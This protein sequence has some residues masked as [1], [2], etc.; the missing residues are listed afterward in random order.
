MHGHLA[1]SRRPDIIE[2][3][4]LKAFSG[5]ACRGDQREDRKRST[6]Q[7][8]ARTLFRGA[9]VHPS[10]GEEAERARF[11]VMSALVDSTGRPHTRLD[12]TLINA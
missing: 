4:I 2:G 12:V 8:P 3:E 7:A 11:P 9:P 5:R 1:A 10:F 6:C